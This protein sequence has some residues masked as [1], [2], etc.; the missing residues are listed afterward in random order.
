MKKI[1]ILCLHL[2]YGGIEIATTNLANMLS[3]NY[4]VEIISFYNLY[5]KPFYKLNDNIKV[6]FL[7]EGRPNKDEFRNAFRK[8]NVIKMVKEGFKSL[9]ILCK[10]RKLMIKEI[11]HCDSDLIISTRVE[12]TEL[13]SNHY[14]GKAKLVAQEH[15]HHDNNKKYINRIIKSLNN[16]DY[17]MP[18][19]KKMTEFYKKR[20]KGNTKVMYGPLCVDYIPEK[21][22]KKNNK[23]IISI[24]RLSYEKGYF[25]LIDV[26]NLI[27]KEDKECHLHIIGDGEEFDLIKEKI[28]LLKLTK[29]VT[30]YGHKD[31]EFIR[32]KLNE[33]SLYLMTSFKESFGLV[34]LEAAAY[35]IPSIA[36]DCAQGATEIIN[37]KVDGYLIENRDKEKMAKCALEILNNKNKLS[38]MGHE[39]RKK[40]LNYSFDNIKEKWLDIVSK[41]LKD[42]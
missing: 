16:I 8:F 22:S 15:S 7:Y 32:N 11:K 31:K 1:T 38:N 29:N 40:C 17:F 5:G 36:F 23:N 41:I 10:K 33:S 26:F 6:K 19:S 35:G 37:N 20:V 2:G 9:N 24:G 30:L 21:E 4:D 12:I 13:L 14:K 27:V 39:A 18:V 25:D 3:D 34:L 42:K 28:K